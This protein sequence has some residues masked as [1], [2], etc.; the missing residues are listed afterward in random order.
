MP[1]GRNGGDE[2]T[3]VS[4]CALKAEHH[5]HAAPAA[6]RQGPRAQSRIPHA[7]ELP[8]Q[9]AGTPQRLPVHKRKQRSRQAHRRRAHQGAPGGMVV[10]T[11]THHMPS[12]QPVAGVLMPHR[13]G[14]PTRAS[15]APHRH[16][17]AAKP[18]QIKAG[19]IARARGVR[20]AGC[21]SPA[22]G[23]E[24]HGSTDPPGGV[25]ALGQA[26]IQDQQSRRMGTSFRH[27]GPP[28]AT[29]GLGWRNCC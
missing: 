25:E 14:A 11:Q 9:A 18:L 3:G 2:P 16:G 23:P 6:P 29:G 5:A 17:L 27:A 28:Q 12:R 7:A 10:V 26:G 8:Q 1:D 15:H 19:R 4:S 21:R 20:P 22:S 24:S 13:A